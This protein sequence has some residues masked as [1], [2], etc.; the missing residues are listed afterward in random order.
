MTVKRIIVFLF[1]C[2]S[3]SAFAQ[4]QIGPGTS[5]RSDNSTYVVLNNIGLQYDAATASLTNTFKFTGNADVNISGA[6]QPIFTNIQLAKTG[7]AKVVL[8]RSFNLAQSLSFAGGLCDLN[9]N[10]IFLGTNAVLINENENSRIRCMNITQMSPN[11][12]QAMTM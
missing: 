5:W 10:N 11:R 12:L 3:I 8:Q 7:S 4:L 6:N 9:G 1:Q 2:Y